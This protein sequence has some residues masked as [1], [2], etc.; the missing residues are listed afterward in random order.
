MSIWFPTALNPT[1]LDQDNKL[2]NLERD[3]LSDNEDDDFLI[4]HQTLRET[5]RD[6]KLHLNVAK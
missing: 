2:L 5:L 3:D 4:E 1:V 6:L